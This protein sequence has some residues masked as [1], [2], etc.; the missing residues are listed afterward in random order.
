MLTRNV[1]A[2]L[3]DCA[4]LHTDLREGARVFEL[5]LH[6]AGVSVEG[7]G[8]SRGG[9]EHEGGQDASV[10]DKFDFATKSVQH[11][12]ATTVLDRYV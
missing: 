5:H 9:G 8:D 12:S 3:V 7:G 11:R 6:E 1:N 10:D 2:V 4:A